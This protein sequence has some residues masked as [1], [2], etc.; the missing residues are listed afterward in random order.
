MVWDAIFEHDQTVD[1]EANQPY[2][3]DILGVIYVSYMRHNYYKL[4]V[5]M[6]ILINKSMYNL[7]IYNICFIWL[8]ISAVDRF[9]W[10]IKE[11]I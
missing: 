8:H 2:T 4:I 7:L 5:N 6:I 10:Y 11:S 9:V 3:Y 1:C